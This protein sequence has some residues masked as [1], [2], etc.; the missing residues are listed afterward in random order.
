MTTNRSVSTANPQAV[1]FDFDGTLFDATDAIAYAFN[2]ALERFGL[3]AWPRSRVESHIGMPLVD[4]FPI[5]APGAEA[6]AAALNPPDCPYFFFVSK[7][8]GSHE[9]CADY[10]CHSRAVRRWQ[11]PRY[12]LD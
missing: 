2:C 11:N 9:F 8:D 5:A 6:L 3:P 7:N 4:M 1:L 10:A 12:G